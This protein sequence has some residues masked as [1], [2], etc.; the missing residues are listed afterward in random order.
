MLRESTLCA[1]YDTILSGSYAYY[2]FIQP[3]YKK[4]RSK[5]NAAI[6]HTVKIRVIVVEDDTEKFHFYL[7][8]MQQ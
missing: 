2:L 8:C 1:M 6:G 5:T 4:K 3:H 7:Y